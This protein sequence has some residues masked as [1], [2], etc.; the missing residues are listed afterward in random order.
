[1]KGRVSVIN[2]PLILA[3]VILLIALVAVGVWYHNNAEGGFVAEETAPDGLNQKREPPTARQPYMTPV[4]P[5]PLA[6]PL[7][8]AGLWKTIQGAFQVER[9]H[10]SGDEKRLEWGGARK[11]LGRVKRLVKELRG[12]GLE[13]DALFSAAA[14]LLVERRGPGALKMLEG[15]RLLEQDLDQADLDSLSPEERFEYT[16]Q[17]RRNAFGEYMADLLFFT[18]EARGR[19]RLQE[20]ALLADSGLSEEARQEKIIALR[21]ELRVALASRGSSISFPDERRQRREER[22]RARYG[23]SVETMSP[24]ERDKAMWDIYSEELPPDVYEKLAGFQRDF[25]ERVAAR[26]GTEP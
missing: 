2:K 23:D 21:R 6:A 22:L 17:A 3:V 9:I 26:D 12:Q 20:R 14:E 10:H 16:C 18:D 19:H 5:D 7:E 13:G 1:V 4:K 11:D 24:E 25:Q 15:Y 8:D